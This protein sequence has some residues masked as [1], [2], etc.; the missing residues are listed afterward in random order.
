MNH[1]A[2]LSLS[3]LQIVALPHFSW[4]YP[5]HISNAGMASSCS[6]RKFPFFPTL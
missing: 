1:S 2:S 4:S 5:L 3:V 6:R